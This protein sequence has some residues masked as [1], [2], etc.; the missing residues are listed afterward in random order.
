M[1]DFHQKE[2]IMRILVVGAGATGGYFGARLAQAGRDVTFL[3]RPGRAKTLEQQG[4]Q[5]LSPQGNL[6]LHPQ[7]ITADKLNQPYD[8]IL[9]TVKAFYL[10]QAMSDIAPAVGSDTVVMPILNGFRHLETLKARFGAAAVIGGLCKIASTLDEQG[11]VVHLN[12]LHLIA[13]GE[14]AGG[15]SDRI[16]QIEQTFQGAG[17][18][19]HASDD[20]ISEMWEK[21]ILLAS[22]GTITCLMRGTIGQTAR[23]DGG[24]AFALAVIEEITSILEAQGY[25]RNQPFLNQTRGMLTDKNSTMTSSMYRDMIGGNPV[26]ADQILGDLARLADKAGLST[27]LLAA[28]RTHMSVYQ[29]SRTADDA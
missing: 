25:R 14:L 26:E 28:A 10:E 3:V 23:A 22:L 27:P 1:V 19:T 11:R 16:I 17:F 9:L 2:I 18:T 15:R 20:I 13:Y 8:L 12:D 4:L 29:Q 24:E 7:W 5:I 6:T 21:W